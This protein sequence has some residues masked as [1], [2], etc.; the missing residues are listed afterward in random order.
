[1]LNDFDSAPILR[2]ATTLGDMPGDR[3]MSAADE[4]MTIQALREERGLGVVELAGIAGILPDHLRAIEAGV[5]PTLPER[6]ALAAA[7]NVP[8]ERIA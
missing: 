3:P 4:P 1:M 2:A 7:L 8:V 5:D 6:Q